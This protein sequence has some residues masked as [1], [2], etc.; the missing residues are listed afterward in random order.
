MRLRHN[1]VR[2]KVLALYLSELV[3]LYALKLHEAYALLFYDADGN[4]IQK[5]EK[6]SGLK[7]QYS[8][9][10]EN[11]LTSVQIP[12]G[13]LIK[14]GYDG[15][16]RRIWK[17]VGGVFA[18]SKY[19]Y[20]DEDILMEFHWNPV[21][22]QNSY[23]A[24]YVHGPGIDEPLMMYNVYNGKKYF[25]VYDGLGSV[26]DLVDEAGNVR[27]HYEYDS[28]GNMVNGWGASTPYTYTG[29]EYDA[30]TGLYYYR[31][32]Y[33]DAQTGRFVSP[34]SVYDSFND[35]KNLNRY[36]YVANNP[37]TFVDPLG[38]QGGIQ[39]IQNWLSTVFRQPQMLALAGGGG[40]ACATLLA[41]ETLLVVGGTALIGLGIE[42]Y[43]Y[44]SKGGK[45][46]KKD[47]GFIGKSDEWV[48]DN[49]KNTQDSQF[50]K[51]LENELKARKIKNKA[52]RGNK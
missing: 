23:V 9:D 41:P 3:M 32:R 4:L 35:H 30:E 26:T 7:T 31:A 13:P 19:V 5:T 50:K 52:K 21:T 22:S 25:Y 34:D 2:E 15:L 36:V 33:Y 38:Q 27:E 46:H 48:I 29:R 49:Y 39:V 6:A 12:D 16:G 47:T 44:F 28:F 43:I 40:V 20:D 42:G 11:Q 51:R 1:F 8:Y 37:V 18:I 14:F 45:Q 10:A 17:E 24:R